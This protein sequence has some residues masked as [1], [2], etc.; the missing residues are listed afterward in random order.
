MFIKTEEFQCIEKYY[1]HIAKNIMLLWGSTDM[2]SYFSK[3]IIDNRDC[4]RTGFPKR[5]S[6]YIINLMEIHKE[7]FPELIN[8]RILNEKSE[9]RV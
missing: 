8:V 5:V 7:D 4:T 3:L 1:P 6:D 9:E 2:N